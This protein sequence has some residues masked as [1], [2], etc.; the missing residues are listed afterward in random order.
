MR[1]L[2]CLPMLGAKLQLD[3]LST[4]HLEGQSADWWQGVLGVVGFDRPP[5]LGLARVPVSANG[6][7]ALGERHNL[8]EVWRVVGGEAAESCV[9]PR[10]GNRF[11]VQSCGDWL[12]GSLTIDESEFL[13]SAS[14]ALASATAGAYA[15]IF[16]ILETRPR[17]HLIR[18][19]HYLP[20]I[21][22]AADGEERYRH[23][24]V[25]RQM[26][27]RVSGRSTLGAVPAASALGCPA[28]RPISIYFLASSGAP[29]MIENPRQISAYRYPRQ[30]GQFTPTFSRACVVNGV[31]GTNLFVSGTAS[32]VGHETRHPGDAAA[33]TRETLA[34]IDALLCE[35]NRLAGTSH[36]SM[37]SL[38]L[39][40]YVRRR[41]DLA[42]IQSALTA[43]SIADAAIVYLQADVCRE[44]LLVE[45]EA[46]G[47]PRRD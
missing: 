34:N 7:P 14:A 29:T 33:Q 42:A 36:Y 45:I 24:N 37:G 35:A 16:E 28:G 19:W 1:G 21:N 12:F 46:A 31:A 3:Y 5:R 23:F 13:G 20:D 18:A 47:E 30:Y 11:A 41:A 38:K 8:C 15:E 10:N 26:A 22:R 43:E 39:K 44:D 25:A 27:F 2:D 32:I 9:L 17:L 4:D 40:V 6:L